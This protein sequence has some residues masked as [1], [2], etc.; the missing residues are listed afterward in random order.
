M[1]A[2]KIN[3]PKKA[4]LSRL[5]AISSLL[6]GDTLKNLDDREAEQMILEKIIGTMSDRGVSGTGA[7]IA[8]FD[9]KAEQAIPD[10]IYVQLVI[11][12]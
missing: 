7:I 8:D 12:F 2:I 3:N 4:V 5:N 10:S 6:I 11:P 9:L 1:I